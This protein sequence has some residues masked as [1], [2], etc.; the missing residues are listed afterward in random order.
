VVAV[1]YQGLLAHPG[2]LVD[3]PFEDLLPLLLDADAIALKPLMD[4]VKV[5]RR[6]IVRKVF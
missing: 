1:R 3:K 2:H 4:K 5:H 6:H